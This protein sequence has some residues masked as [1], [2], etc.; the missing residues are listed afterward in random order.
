[1]G[2]AAGASADHL[3]QRRGWRVRSVRVAMQCAAMLGPA[4][5]LTLAT[6][7]WGAHSAGAAVGFITLGMG[8]SALASSESVV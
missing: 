7:P 5:A 8:M 2:V 1:V 6:S 4:V 3:I